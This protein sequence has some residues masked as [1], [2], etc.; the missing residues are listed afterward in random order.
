MRIWLLTVGEPLPGL[1][2]DQRILRT[3]MLARALVD[4]GQE[5]VWWTSAFD[6]SRKR[7]RFERDE[8]IQADERLQL[9]LL[10]SI[11]YRR[12][13][14][15]ARV[16]NHQGLARK[17]KAFAAGEAPPALILSSL[18]LIELSFE[19]VQY[20]RSRGI[21]VVLDVRDLWPDI[22]LDL[23]PG[24]AR[25]LGRVLLQGMF[26]KTAAA[27]SGCTSVV[28]VSDRYL[29]WGLAK[30]GRARR[31]Q[32]A[33]FPLGYQKP[34]IGEKRMAVAEAS[35]RTLGVDADKV[36]CWFIGIFGRSYDLGT[37]I[38]AAREL[39]RRGVREVSFVLSGDGDYREKWQSQTAGLENVVFTGW[40][41]APQI[42]Y[43]LSVTSVG[44][45]AYTKGAPQGLPNKIFEYLSAGLPVLSSLSGET[46]A[47]LAR[48]ACGLTYRAGD[49]DSFMEALLPLLDDRGRR[50]T[51]GRN[52]EALFTST[53]SAEKVYS[54]MAG[55]LIDLAARQAP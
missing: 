32:D 36:I 17:F 23:F 6:H 41:D 21:P 39:S 5:V 49:P 8:T 45:A 26:R 14:S 55:F 31:P 54:R 33:V 30:A 15:F 51:M 4:A 11:G 24:K 37:V 2:D 29:E 1:E 44:L 19:A 3:G 34:A 35:L 46:E 50:E 53:F 52:A 16:F 38:E 10:H 27:F 20:G 47:L 22:I 9:K 13:I 12:N 28:G 25:W 42:A 40:L 48:Q 43:L 18:P 7:H